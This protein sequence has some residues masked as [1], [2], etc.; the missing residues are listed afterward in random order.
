MSEV[1][2]SSTANITFEV[3]ECIVKVVITENNIA[4]S[5]MS[6]ETFRDHLQFMT[7]EAAMKFCNAF[8]RMVLPPTTNI[9]SVS[10]SIDTPK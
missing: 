6:Q 8:Q 2:E 5:G 4:W 10:V 7:P 1:P 9:T 3:N